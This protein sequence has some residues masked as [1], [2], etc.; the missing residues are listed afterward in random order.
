VSMST[1][2]AL[3]SKIKNRYQR[4]AVQLFGRRPFRMKN[5]ETLISFTFDDFPRS[6]LHVAGASLERHALAGTYYTSL[7][8]MGQLAPTGEMFL[9]EDLSAVLARGHEL[10]CHTYDHCHSYDTTPDDFERSILT[11]QQVLGSLNPTVTFKSL[12]YPISWPRVE[13]KRR[14]ARYFLGCRAGGQTHN[15]GTIDLNYLSSFF[16]EQ[17]RD[18]LPSIRRVIEANRQAGGWLIFATHD[19]CANP[20]RYGC[21]P[22]LFDSVLHYSIESGAKILSVSSALKEIGAGGE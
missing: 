16:L 18:D 11:N 2:S 15:E 4:T 6:A 19:V 20:T 3:H 14:C 13:T 5:R 1:I 17:S 10:A 9:Q 7:G 21:T 8:L 12:S 22:E